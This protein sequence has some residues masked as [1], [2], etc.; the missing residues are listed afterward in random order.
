MKLMEFIDTIKDEIKDAKIEKYISDNIQFEFNEIEGNA[1]KKYKIINCKYHYND[2]L[3]V[4]FYYF[5]RNK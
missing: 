1:N 4:N 5:Y 2:I 3:F